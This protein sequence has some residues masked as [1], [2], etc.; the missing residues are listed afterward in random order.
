MHAYTQISSERH[1]ERTD[2]RC[3]Y[4]TNCAGKQNM[5]RKKKEKKEHNILSTSG[6]AA[7]AATAAAAVCDVAVCYSIWKPKSTSNLRS[8]DSWQCLVCV[9]CAVHTAHIH[10]IAPLLI[11]FYSNCL[12]HWTTFLH[13]QLPFSR[14]DAFN[15][16]VWWKRL[17]PDYFDTV[18]INDERGIRMNSIVFWDIHTEKWM[19]R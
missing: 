6:D 14:R 5:N 11:C 8:F 7:A 18:Y 1:R 19:H 3:S 17:K 13:L 9:L 2:S 16:N 10:S 4:G 12:A 15:E